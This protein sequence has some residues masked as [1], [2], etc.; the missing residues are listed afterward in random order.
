MTT[1]L[2]QRNTSGVQTPKETMEAVV[3][4][5]SLPMYTLTLVYMLYIPF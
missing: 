5:L 1:C 2:A 4:L 3:Y